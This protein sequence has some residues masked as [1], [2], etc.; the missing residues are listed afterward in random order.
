AKSKIPIKVDAYVHLKDAQTNSKI[1]HID[2]ESDELNEI[3]K[4][5]ESTYCAGKRGGMFIGLK[6]EMLER[7]KKKYHQ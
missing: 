3:I 1:I 6:K 7:A 5:G 2:I 4:P